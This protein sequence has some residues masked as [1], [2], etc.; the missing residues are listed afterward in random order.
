MEQE[1]AKRVVKI[2]EDLRH[3][4]YNL[5]DWNNASSYKKE[6]DVSIYVNG[7]GVIAVYLGEY[8]PFN[9]LKAMIIPIIEE[10]ISSLEIELNNI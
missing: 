1:K 9:V 6:D 8:M 2:M 3:L 7:G 5:N 4:K 10:R